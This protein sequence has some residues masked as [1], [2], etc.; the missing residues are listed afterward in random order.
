VSDDIQAI[1]MPKW[2]LSMDEGTV[3]AWH[4][5]EGAAVGRGDEVVDIETPKI[6]NVCESTVSGTLRRRVVQEGTTAPV[7]A[8]IAVVADAAVPEAE[9]DTF[10][11][12]FNAAFTVAAAEA[13][14]E[15]IGPETVAVDGRAINHLT[16]GA[17]DGSP[18]VLVHGFGGDLNNWMFNQPVLAE[19]HL[20]TALDLPGHG[21]SSKD[22][23]AGDLGFLAETLVRFLAALGIERAHLA[24]HSLGG[25]VA[26]ELAL[27]RP[28]TV[29]SLTLVAPAGLGPEIDNGYIEGFI[30]AGRRKEMKTALETLFADPSLVSRDMVNDVLKYKRLDGVEAALKTIAAA[31]FPGG[32]QARVMRDRLPQL[33]MPAQVIWGRHDRI[34]PAAQAQGL[35][36]N[37]AVHLLDGAGHMAHMEA[38]GEVNRLIDGVVA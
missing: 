21:G 20:V 10:V 12:R 6:T 38:A 33:S 15:A 31:A 13:E 5:A 14:A 23:G 36:G 28:E 3:V 24:G 25:A 19:R 32:R 2:G 4:V 16:L 11:E 35:P 17:A 9:I 7:G 29:A 27:E 26:L 22:V 30:A 8:L 34:I 1:T 18:V 37:V